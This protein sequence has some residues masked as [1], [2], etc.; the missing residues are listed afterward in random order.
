MKTFKNPQ[1]KKLYSVWSGMRRRC[2]NPNHIQFRDYGGRGIEVCHEW[3]TK[4]GFRNFYNWALG[5]GFSP[6]LT[7][8]RINTNGGYDPDNC[9]W[10]TM[11]V[12]ERN[13]RVRK[14]NKI[15]VPGVTVRIGKKRISY[16]VTICVDG[17]ILSVGTFK[18]LLEAAN[19][20]IQAEEKYWG[21]FNEYP[22]ISRIAS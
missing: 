11:A 6:D 2:N 21:F 20:R 16:R 15:G 3:N 4:N 8:D 10:S 13:R 22:L 18:S 14:T 9:R 12:Q 7:I 5:S 19:A 1:E 17:K